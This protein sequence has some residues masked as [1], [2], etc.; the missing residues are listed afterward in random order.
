MLCFLDTDLV[1]TERNPF[2]GQRNE[3][4]LR[5]NPIAYNREMS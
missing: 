1:K 3:T 4:K 2:V 5:K